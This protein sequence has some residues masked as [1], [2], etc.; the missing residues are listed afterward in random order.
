[1]SWTRT[2]LSLDF[3]LNKSAARIKTLDPIVQE[4]AKQLI[5]DCWKEGIAI[6]IVQANRTLAEQAK[7]YAQGRTVPGNIVTNAKPGSS[8]HN[9]GNAIDACILNEDGKNVIWED[10]T[11]RWKR[12]IE[13]AEARGWKSG[14][15]FSGKFKDYPHFEYTQGY[16]ISYFRNGGK[17]KPTGFKAQIPSN[18]TN[19]NSILIKPTLKKGSHGGD[20]ILLQKK[21][22]EAGYLVAIDGIFGQ[23]VY[24]AVVLLQSRYGCVQDGIVGEKTWIA[25][26][27][28]IA[29]LKKKHQNQEIEQ[30]PVQF[31][32]NTIT[33]KELM[34]VLEKWK[35]DLGVHGVQELTK[36]G[37]IQEPKQWIEKLDK[38][39][40][41]WLFFEM[42]NRVLEKV[43]K[44][45]E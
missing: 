29:D 37:L 18:L 41:N 38:P 3:L 15:K 43:E 39:V 45:G 7:L 13:L 6:V 1:M 44:G 4:Y 20:V 34:K 28:A 36:K 42:L 16:P 32:I 33:L 14:S 12:V 26:E 27:K 30:N 35:I 9:F 25:I 19:G 5:I 8:F 40:E 10:T 11:P 22:N 31:Q 23:S 2:N 24:N 21:L 17:L